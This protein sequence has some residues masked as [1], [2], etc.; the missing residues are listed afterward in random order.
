MVKH[1]GDGTAIERLELVSA[2]PFERVTYT[3]AVEML[4]NADREFENK[5]EWGIDL[6]SEHERYG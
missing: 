3:K 2:T 5:V 6:S 1:S 4:E